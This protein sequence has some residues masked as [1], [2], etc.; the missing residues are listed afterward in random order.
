MQ[1]LAEP[2]QL[3]YG[4]TLFG[5]VS[6]ITCHQGTWLGIVD[7]TILIEAGAWMVRSADGAATQIVDGAPNFI[8][9]GEISWL[10][11]DP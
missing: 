8:G 10:I 11:K 5:L 3:F 2:A 9:R 7:I 4:H 1:S 6:R